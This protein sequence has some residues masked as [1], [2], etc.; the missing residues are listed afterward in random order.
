MLERAV[1]WIKAARFEFLTGSMMPVFACGAMAWY[2]THEFHWGYWVLTLLGMMFIHSGA[3]LANDYYDHV[4]GNDEANVEF[5][6][7][8]TG[9]SRLIQTGEVRARHI[10]IASLISF[11]VGSAIGF[12][13]VWARG[14]WILAF[15]AIG[16]ISAFFYTAPPLKLGYRGIGEPFIALNFGIL[17]AIGTYYVQ[18]QELSWAAI[19][20]G[21]PSTFLITAVLFIN[22]FQD[23][24]ADAS[25]GKRHWVVRLGR[26]RSRHI[27]FAL[28]LAAPISLVAAV[29]L[30]WL[31]AAAL[32]ALAPV[33]M[34][35]GMFKAAYVHYEDPQKL[36]PANAG[37]VGMHLLTG[38]L[39]TVGIVIGG[40]A[41]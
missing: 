7:P 34:L 24:K 3:N 10:L 20:A 31:P 12:Y 18:A 36:A 21:L 14:L 38:I 40:A 4:S 27:Y 37:T 39:V 41:G 33:L 17:P 13:L 22:Q 26:R 25:V 15:G 6:R 19:A 23:M 5:L 8:F 2:V 28:V 11:A 32:I 1:F 16:V 9:G 29:V 35:P 30:G